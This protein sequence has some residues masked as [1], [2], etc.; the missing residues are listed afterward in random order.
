MRIGVLGTGM[1]G[2]TIATKLVELGH[3]VTMGSVEGTNVFVCGEEDTAKD[4]VKAL[5]V[6][7][8]WP[9]DSVLD[10]G[11]IDG[12][13]GMEMYLPL[14]LRLMGALGTPRF[15]IAVVE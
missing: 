4:E 15:N 12:A 5:L 9:A 13:R 8:G 10:L 3:D 2:R 14:W 6:D 11:D 7:F 1:V